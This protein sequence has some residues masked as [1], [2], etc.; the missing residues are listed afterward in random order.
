VPGYQY[1]LTAPVALEVGADR[2]EFFPR[3]DGTTGTAW[4]KNLNDGNALADAL[5]HGV[6]AVAF[7]TSTRGTRT[8]DTF[9]LAGYAEAMAKAHAACSS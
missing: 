6:S 1:K 5:N 8:V 3:N 9:S 7:G 4:L 2:F